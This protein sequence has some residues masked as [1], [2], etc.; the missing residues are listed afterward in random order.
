MEKNGDF[1]ETG[2]Y[3]GHF[4]G[5]LKPKLNVESMKDLPTAAAEKSHDSSEHSCETNNVKN[6]EVTV[7]A[8]INGHVGKNMSKDGDLTEDQIVLDKHFIE[9]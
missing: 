8:E 4:Y 9:V 6:S 2:S 3:N 7:H 5:T 1:I